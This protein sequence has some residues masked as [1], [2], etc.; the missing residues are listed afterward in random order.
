MSSQITNLPT[1]ILLAIASHLDRPSLVNLAVTCKML[2]PVAEK[3]IWTHLDLSIRSSPAS[4]II[5]NRL[6]RVRDTYIW[7]PGQD[8]VAYQLTIAT[9]YSEVMKILHHHLLVHPL[10]LRHIRRITVDIDQLLCDSF[11]DLL[12]LTS[13]TLTS[14]ELLP[15]EYVF[16]PSRTQSLFTLA[17]VFLSLDAPL[18]ALRHLQ[19]TLEENWQT[20]LRFALR[21]APYLRS[22]R[23]TPASA[24]AGGWGRKTIFESPD[25][26]HWPSMSYLRKVEV[27]E[28]SEQLADMLTYLLQ[29]SDGITY[30]ALRDQSGCWKPSSSDPLVIILGQQAKLDYLAMSREAFDTL[31]KSGSVP[32]IKILSISDKNVKHT[33]PLLQ[34]NI[35]PQCETITTMYLNGYSAL[36]H[37]TTSFGWDEEYQGLPAPMR[38]IPPSFLDDIHQSKNLKVVLFP[39][40]PYEANYP[41]EEFVPTE[42]ILKKTGR[43]ILIRTYTT[44]DQHGNQDM[45]THCRSY[46]AHHTHVTDS[47][48]HHAQEVW[49]EY[50]DFNGKYVDP[51]ILGKV[52]STL[53]AEGMWIEGGR[54]LRMP[55]E[56][57]EVLRKV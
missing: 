2:H 40:D 50:T 19:I 45:F 29:C 16:G 33:L 53:G 8:E 55:S 23:I 11:L 57:W 9:A 15:P 39:T 28:M 4:S 26:R 6:S 46:S 44:T 38:T 47:Y 48:A 20:P 12:R 25:G 31:R 7:Q 3:A 10:W 24:H 35:I 36:A 56:A 5:K 14:L 1:H 34:F 30:V 54:D 37:G 42:E 32:P 21:C 52:Y 51:S 13:P 27:D 49:E 18:V 41:G 17:Q 22:L 43:A